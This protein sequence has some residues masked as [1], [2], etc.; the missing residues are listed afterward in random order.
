MINL[1]QSLFGLSAT[2]FFNG[3][4][5]NTC[6]LRHPESGITF[7]VNPQIDYKKV[8]APQDLGPNQINELGVVETWFITISK[9]QLIKELGEAINPAS[10]LPAWEDAVMANR[11][12]EVTRPHETVFIEVRTEGDPEMDDIPHYG[13]T[14]KAEAIG[15]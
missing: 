10:N 5:Y 14:L 1:T 2:K 4:G 9:E 6:K 11:K 3:I 8:S 15:I 13:M 7:A 12:W